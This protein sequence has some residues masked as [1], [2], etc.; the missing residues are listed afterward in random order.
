MG[1]VFSAIK[2]MSDRFTPSQPTPGHADGSSSPFPRSPAPSKSSAP[3][4]QLAASSKRTRTPAHARPAPDAVS[5]AARPKYPGRGRL[6]HLGIEANE[7]LTGTTALVLLVLLAIEG[8]TIVRVQFAL[9]APRVHWST[10]GAA[11]HRQDVEHDV[12]LCK[13]LPRYAGVSPQ[14]SAAGCRCRVLGPFT[15]ILTAIV[16]VTGFLLLLGP[17]SMRNEYFQLHRASFIAWFAVMVIHVLG[18]V[19]DMTRSSTKDWTR[20]TRKLVAGARAR[21]VV[22]AASLVVGL[23]FALVIVSYVG[24]W[25]RGS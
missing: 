1:G 24:P 25:S 4:E 2:P 21:R 12:A 16:F 10:A 7:R 6:A 17:T 9:D 15:V 22:L 14:G 23:G 19:G 5:R 3:R 20:R 18:H 13:V 8:A 11:R